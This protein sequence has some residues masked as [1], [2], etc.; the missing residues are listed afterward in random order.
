MHCRVD[1]WLHFTFG[2]TVSRTENEPL[3]APE[4]M[5]SQLYAPIAPKLLKI[6]EKYST[7]EKS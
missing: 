5:F 4:T 1:A 2:S 3:K 6:V 7:T